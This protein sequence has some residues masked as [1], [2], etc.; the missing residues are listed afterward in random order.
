MKNE[1]QSAK[2]NLTSISSTAF[3][4]TVRSVCGDCGYILRF[5]SFVP[6]FLV[7]SVSCGASTGTER[8]RL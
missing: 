4:C 8:K 1:R 6:V 3:A 7:C 5:S 2:V